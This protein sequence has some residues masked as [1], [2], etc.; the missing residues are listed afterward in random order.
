M[1]IKRMGCFLSMSELFRC[2]AHGRDNV[3][4]F[5]GFNHR[6]HQGIGV[7]EFLLEHRG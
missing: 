2:L 3:Q 7:L 5:I 1:V 4:S 6:F